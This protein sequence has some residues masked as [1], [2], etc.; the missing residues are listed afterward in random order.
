MLINTLFSPEFMLILLLFSVG[1]TVL[2]LLLWF[3]Q[4][5][6]A[7][8]SRVLLEDAL[9]DEQAKTHQLEQQIQEGEQAYTQLQHLLEANKDALGQAQIAL[10][11]TEVAL[12]LSE[13][14]LLAMTQKHQQQVQEGERLQELCHALEKEKLAL[15]LSVEEKEKTLAAQQKQF[16][17]VQK[18]LQTQFENLANRI[19]AEKSQV[20]STQNQTQITQLLKPFKEQL[21]GFQKRVNEVHT[22]SVAGQAELKTQIGHIKEMGVRMSEEAQHLTQALSGNKKVLGNWGEMQLEAAF[23][24]AGLQKEVNYLTQVHLKDEE[25][26]TQ[27]P[28]F[29]LLLPDNKQLIVDSKVSLVAYQKAVAETDAAQAQEHLKQLV[30]DVRNH[31]NG[32]AEKDYAG[33]QG[34]QSL[35]FVL[36]FMPLEAAFMEVLRQD[37]SLFQDAYRKGVVVVSQTTL[38]PTLRMIANLWMLANSNDLAMQLGDKAMDLYNQV[39]VV[40]EHLVKLGNN[41]NTVNKQYNQVVTS[42]AGNQG[43]NSKLEKFTALSARMP[44]EM[45]SLEEVEQV[46]DTSK[47]GRIE[48]VLSV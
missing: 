28:D 24:R 41:L 47:L 39:V 25:G 33:L 48:G 37:D 23:E 15:T 40:A 12:Q 7:R 19:L 2:I 36:M 35:G 10:G 42:F 5:H 45:P 27:I 4:T 43:V 38:M 8:T 26:R 29:V 13:Q 3:M 30:K 34:E 17:Q 1:L 9:N 22:Q 44:K 18:D 46:A 14:S 31:V 21:E 6:K 32:L 11:K 20:F 16:E